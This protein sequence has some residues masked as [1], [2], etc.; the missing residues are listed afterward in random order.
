MRPTLSYGLRYRY[1]TIGSWVF[2]C[3]EY[4]AC[5]YIY[6]INSLHFSCWSVVRVLP[7]P[8]GKAVHVCK[9]L[10]R[11]MS[12]F[13]HC[14]HMYTLI[15]GVSPFILLVITIT[16]NT[17][18]GRLQE[19]KES[20]TWKYFHSWP[21]SGP[22]VRLISLHYIQH[23]SLSRRCMEGFLRSI[24]LRDCGEPLTSTGRNVGRWCNWSVGREWYRVQYTHS[25]PS[26]I[27][28]LR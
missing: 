1:V 20:W 21:E 13:V 25:L 26:M 11:N 15:P 5:M 24:E 2:L 8:S 18:I 7:H 28:D 3:W 14:P 16:S 23:C 22:I 10:I 12:D 27:F 4:C 9:L 17:D 19:R 6:V